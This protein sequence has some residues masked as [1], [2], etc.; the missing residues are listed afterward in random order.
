[1]TLV[2]IA[3]ERVERS[4]RR[5]RRRRAG[6]T[7]AASRRRSSSSRCRRRRP[8][9][10]RPAR[11]RRRRLAT[12]GA[13]SAR[14]GGRARRAAGTAAG[15]RR[16]SSRGWTGRLEPGGEPWPCT[17]WSSARPCRRGPPRSWSADHRAGVRHERRAS[18]S[19]SPPARSSCAAASAGGRRPLAVDDGHRRPQPAGRGA[20]AQPAR[21]VRRRGAGRRPARRPPSRQVRAQPLQRHEDQLLERDVAGRRPARRRR[22]RGRR[23]RGP[24]RR[25]LAQP[26]ATASAAARRS[27]AVC[28]PKDT[29]GF[30][31]VRPR[32]RPAMPLLDAVVGVN[33]RLGDRVDGELEALAQQA[34]APARALDLREPPLAPP[35]T[36]SGRRCTAMDVAGA[37]RRATVARPARRDVVTGRPGLAAPPFRWGCWAWPAGSAG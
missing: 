5:A 26:G 18:G 17:P 10:V 22:R 12:S 6:S 32:A 16:G 15:A 19:A 31:G 37:G 7:C 21:A 13:R 29:D 34:A 27:P 1:M 23:H 20:A 30:L 14:P 36:T 8:R 33:S 9:G 24:Q 35:R 28:L 4:A 11:D 3:P 2:D 25:G